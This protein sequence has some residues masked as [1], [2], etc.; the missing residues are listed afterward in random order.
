MTRG[1]SVVGNGSVIT[2]TADHLLVSGYQD[3]TL[4]VEDGAS[5]YILTV[6]TPAWVQGTGSMQAT[7]STPKSPARTI[8]YY[9]T[10][11]TGGAFSGATRLVKQGEGTLTLP[12]VTEKHTGETNIWQGTLVFNGTMESSPVWLNRHTTLISDGGRFMG[13]LRADYN[14][15]IY[16]GGK[17]KTGTLTA[18]TLTLGFGSKVVFDVLPPASLAASALQ[19]TLEVLSVQGDNDL[20][21]DQLNAST[22]VVDTRDWSFGPKYKTPVFQINAL[23]ELPSGSYLLGNV[24]R[25]EGSVTDILVEG[26][27]GKRFYLQH[28]DGKLFLVLE[29]MRDATTVVWNGT[30]ESNVW[31]LA[32]T[33]NFTNDGQ[34][35]YAAQGDDIV[36][37]DNAATGNVVVKGAVSPNS[38]TFNNSSLAY[39]LTGDS[40]LGGGTI[41][42]NGTAKVTINTEN[43]T[44]TTTINEGTLVVNALANVTGI[45]YGA[46]GDVSQKITINDGATLSVSQPVIT[47][48]P[49]AVSGAATLDVPTNM[50]FTLNKG[51]KGTG[52]IVTKTGAGTLT[53]GPQNTFG[54]LVIK[55]GRVND[56]AY[57][58]TDQLPAMVEFQGG[59]LWAD[60]DE[61]TNINNNAGFV[62]PKGKTG[63]LY[64]GYRSTYKGSLTGAGTFNV[65]T[66][67]IR[68]Y[69]DGDWS[70]FT[71]TIKTYKNNRQ[72]KK[73]YDPVW[74]FRNSNGLPNATL[75]TQ[76]DVLVS[77][78]G[79]NIE[80]GTLTGSGTLIGSGQWILG[81]N[82][83]NFTLT[84]EIGVTSSRTD[85]YGNTISVSPSKLT[86]RGTGKM[87]IMT[88]GKINATLTVEQ[89][90]VSFNQASL[91]TYVNGTNTTTVKD[92]GRIVGQG[93]FN[94]MVLQSG[95]ELMPCGSY[96]NETTPG[97]IKTVAMLNAQKGSVVNFIVKSTEKYSM[98]TPSLL[99][100]NATVRLTLL[101]DYSPAVGD[102]FTLWT[103][104]STF[105]GTPEYDL[106]ALPAGM[107]WDTDGLAQKTGVLRIVEAKTDKADVNVDGK[108]DV[109]DISSIL[110]VMAGSGSEALKKAADVNAD[111]VVDVA[112]IAS[113]L[114]EMAARSRAGMAEE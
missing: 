50:T 45:T 107:A 98:L 39:T 21:F 74:A 96:V 15:T 60:N 79:S 52:A 8:I 22:L 69:F 91:E 65:Y 70:E 97:T 37:D 28:T 5:P 33:A 42:K 1:R 102:E 7:A 83:A 3:Q 55:Q 78:E 41:T 30:A 89:G 63:T 88:L 62:V 51:L 40:I 43:R 66:G 86:K 61:S 35:V 81:G 110:T 24:D 80:I 71:G 13:G 10:T 87:T 75:S 84:T 9:N 58:H 59:T 113:V 4:S 12:A 53:L 90:T 109:A 77:N 106:P 20:V 82:D 38:I 105:S 26:I 54:Q 111:G 49:F 48:Q 6:N 56:I 76:K 47:D 68:C 114:T 46:L 31:D 36:F 94:S 34:S 11:L 32:E 104:T 112:D 92:G 16:A 64:A 17:D 101:D 57:N 73:S 67:G 100:M 85:P 27:S 103:V 19:N 23:S 25:V 72:N 14:A 18:S 108:V 44:G 95:A 99:T 29:D 93:K 2:T